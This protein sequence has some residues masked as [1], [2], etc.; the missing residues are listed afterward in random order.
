MDDAF[1]LSWYNLRPY[2]LLEIHSADSIVRL[3]REVIAH[4]IR[5]YFE[6]RIRALR[7]VSRD[8][9][10]SSREGFVPRVGRKLS[11]GRLVAS[12]PLT[13]GMFR[14]KKKTKLEWR[15]RWVVIHQGVLSLCKDRLVSSLPVFVFYVILIQYSFTGP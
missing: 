12:D 4:Y 9:W 3:P 7:V 5:P 11:K 14:E 10:Q 15:E 13:Y 2:E 1:C 8:H 6:A